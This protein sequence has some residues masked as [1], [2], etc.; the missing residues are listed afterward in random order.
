MPNRSEQLLIRVPGPHLGGDRGWL[1]AALSTS[2]P[3]L[4]G[5]RTVL[6]LSALASWALRDIWHFADLERPLD[7]AAYRGRA[8]VLTAHAVYCH[9]AGDGTPRRYLSPDPTG[10]SWNRLTVDRDG[11][12]YVLQEGDVK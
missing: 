1:S 2:K 8:Y 12:V 7:V 10:P 5:G 11:Q 4:A 6:L 9:Q 3:S